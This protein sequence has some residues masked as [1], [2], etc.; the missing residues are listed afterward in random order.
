MQDVFSQLMKWH[1]SQPRFAAWWTYVCTTF[2]AIMS[3][4]FFMNWALRRGVDPR[5][6]MGVFGV[7]LIG[8][9]MIILL[10]PIRA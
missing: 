1:Y 2:L 4:I 9:S 3:I 5:Y 7:V 8:M 10:R 6:G